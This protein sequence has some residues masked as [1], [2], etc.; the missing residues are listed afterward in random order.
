MGDHTLYGFCKGCQRWVPRDEMLSINTALYDAQNRKHVI[1]HRYCPP[2][3][4]TE[5]ARVQGRMWDH[6]VV[7]E[8]DLAPGTDGNPPTNEEVRERRRLA[9][10]RPETEQPRVG[11]EI[12]L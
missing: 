7:T 12:R 11:Q 6:I 5:R 1:R 10:L 9:R 8:S 4:E 3:Y 2:C